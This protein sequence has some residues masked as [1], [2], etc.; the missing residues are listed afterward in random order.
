[1]FLKHKNHHQSPNILK[2][3]GCILGFL[4][5]HYRKIKIHD[6]QK[7]ISFLGYAW[8]TGLSVILFVTFLWAYF[9]NDFTFAIDINYFG[10]AHIELVFLS[11]LAIPVICYGL[12]V[13][14]N[15]MK[16]NAPA[17]T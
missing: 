17:K 8:A 9:S 1:M 16:K 5:T 13:S 6:K 7:V 4:P 12:Y 11:L 2:F 3:S 15:E 14:Y 10:E